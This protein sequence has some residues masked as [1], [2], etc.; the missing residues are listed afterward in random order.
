[1][2]HVPA[3]LEH[4]LILPVLRLSATAGDCDCAVGP[5]RTPEVCATL[6]SSSHTTAGHALACP[7][8]PRATPCAPLRRG[9]LIIHPLAALT[10]SGLARTRQRM[11][12]HAKFVRQPMA[13][14]V[15]SCRVR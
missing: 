1:M 15:L 7:R 2:K 5:F 6:Q 3:L 11:M 8:L 4:I 13:R 10:P 14:P 12:C 9:R